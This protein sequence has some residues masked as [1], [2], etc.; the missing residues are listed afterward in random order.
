MQKIKIMIFWIFIEIQI[1]I[2]SSDLKRVFFVRGGP[3]FSWK[4]E[5]SHEDESDDDDDDDEEE[6]ADEDYV[7][8]EFVEDDE[9]Y[10][11]VYLWKFYDGT[12]CKDM[13]LCFWYSNSDFSNSGEG[14]RG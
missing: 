2:W 10:E 13:K 9:V 11:V 5:F 14:G 8:V 12:A 6:E 7:E 1:R 4:W 3:I